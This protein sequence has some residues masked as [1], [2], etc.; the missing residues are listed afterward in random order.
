MLLSDVAAR[1]CIFCSPH[2]CPW[3]PWK[4][5][6]RLLPRYRCIA[7]EHGSGV[8]WWLIVYSE[9]ID[10]ALLANL[11]HQHAKVRQPTAEV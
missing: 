6:S 11:Q 3:L 4:T 8:V 5:N 7:S 1:R 9:L 2:R 10:Q